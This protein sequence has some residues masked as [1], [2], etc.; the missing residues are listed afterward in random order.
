MSQNAGKVGISGQAARP[1]SRRQR[2]R[3]ISR[4]RLELGLFVGAA[5]LLARAVAA[6]AAGRW[7]RDWPPGRAGSE[8]VATGEPGELVVEA[9]RSGGAHG[10][11]LEGQRVGAVGLD[12]VRPTSVGGASGGSGGTGRRR[13]RCRCSR[14]PPTARRGGCRTSTGRRRSLGSPVAGEHG[15][16]LGGGEGAGGAAEVQEPAVGAEQQLHRPAG[17]DRREQA[18]GD[19][20]AVEGGG[21][22]AG[23]VEGVE[24]QAPVELAEPG[25]GGEEPLE[26]GG[27][28]DPGDPQPGPVEGDDV[29]GDGEPLAAPVPVGVLERVEVALAHLDAAR[30]PGVASGCVVRRG[31]RRGWQRSSAFSIGAAESGSKKPRTASSSSTR[32]ADSS[33]S[34]TTSA[35]AMPASAA[36]RSA[37]SSA[38]SPS[39]AAPARSGG[40]SAGPGS[41]IVSSMVCGEALDVTVGH[42]RRRQVDLGGGQPTATPRLAELGPRRHPGRPSGDRTGSGS[43]MR[44]RCRSND[45][46]VGEPVDLGQPRCGVARPR[47]R[48]RPA[49]RR[50]LSS[51]ASAIASPST[52]RSRPSIAS[53]SHWSRSPAPPD[54][55]PDSVAYI[56]SIN[57]RK[58]NKTLV[59]TP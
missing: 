30:R 53:R 25:P 52:A 11:V 44:Q 43:V 58:R 16:A 12:A 49:S 45:G 59:K 36:S 24:E 28:D 13:C 41:S 47:R 56:S 17:G 9:R 35:G 8:L 23:A 50:S 38:C 37:R 51:R 4:V 19:G 6:G 26:V 22:A 18:V 1:S 40:R 7:R 34:G 15:P 3:T 48:R 33:R 42:E 21:D 27:G 2:S 46:H 39:G 32:D 20:V 5:V 55:M 54:P 57:N 29:G 14:R 10:A 31:G